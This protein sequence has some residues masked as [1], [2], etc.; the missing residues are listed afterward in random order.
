MKEHKHKH[1]RTPI[2]SAIPIA[3]SPRPLFRYCLIESDSLWDLS[4]GRGRGTQGS[5]H[6]LSVSWFSNF[7]YLSSGFFFINLLKK[8][9]ANKQIFQRQKN[10]ACI[11]KCVLFRTF[12]DA[13]GG[14]FV[15]LRHIWNTFIQL[16]CKQHH[17]C[18]SIGWPLFIFFNQPYFWIVTMKN[19]QFL[20]SNQC[21]RNGVAYFY[22]P[23]LPFN[24]ERHS[25]PL[26]K[27]LEI[28]IFR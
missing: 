11:C 2:F 5:H 13:R 9:F 27:T 6:P 23:T 20:N 12:F 18:Q 17:I 21:C 4:G 10:D 19:R 26:S 14:A 15:R 28:G 8:G 22:A 25:A 24:L 7:G 1:D 3:S 16:T